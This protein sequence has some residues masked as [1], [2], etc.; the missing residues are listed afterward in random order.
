MLSSLYIENIAVIEKTIIDFTEG[1]NLLTGETGAGKSIVI[2]SIN[3]LLGHRTSKDIIRTGAAS[4]FVSGSFNNPSE[5]VISQLFDMGYEIK[6]GDDL[7]LER[8]ITSSGKNVCRINGRPAPLS[9]LREIAS[10]LINIHGQH[11]SYQLM[12][13]DKHVTYIDSLGNINGDLEIYAELFHQLKK[14]KHKLDNAQ[15]DDSQRER[16]IDLLKYQISE[17]EQA[18][19]SPNEY[20][21]L[22]EEKNIYINS[23]KITAALESAYANLNGANDNSGALEALEQA[24]I[25]LAGITEYLPEA[26]E[27]SDRLSSAFY[28]LQDC[29]A[30]ISSLTNDSD[31]DP[32]RL[33]E[34]EERLDLIYKLSR[35]YGST[36]EEMLIFLDKSRQELYEL[37]DYGNNIEKLQKQFDDV[38]EKTR[39]QALKISEKRKKTADIFAKKVKEELTYLDMPNVTLKVSQERCPLNENGCDKI[40]F[41]ISTNPGEPPKPVSKIASG[42]ELS[43]MMLAIKNVISGK[44]T[45]D[46][47]IFDEVDTGISGSAAQ[48]VG[49]KLKK[50]SAEKQVICVTHQAQIAALADSH[51]LIQKQVIGGRTYTKV[52]LL[53][54][55]GRKQELARIIGGVS[56]TELTLK[57]AEEMLLSS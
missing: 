49:I 28:E 55:E 45:V 13:P 20:E 25:E 21:E 36:T 54:F 4:C 41:L 1:F 6:D 2:D 9:V 30:E 40:E 32:Y 11:E 26:K 5:K 12:T 22:T 52:E 18:D 15:T 8:K 38:L 56:I 48:K 24:S 42:G 29:A 50:L 14:C 53:D 47:L 33:E 7:I 10:G 17:L 43:R 27:L 16:K 37:E 46:T 51:F 31:L 39:K 44:D 34:I 3:A 23:E 19:L 57:H 35:K